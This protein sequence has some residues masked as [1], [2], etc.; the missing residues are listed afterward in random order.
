METPYSKSTILLGGDLNAGFQILSS[1][2]SIIHN[3]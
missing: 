2:V 1:L 3:N